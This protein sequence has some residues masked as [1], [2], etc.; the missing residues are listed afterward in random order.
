MQR[1]AL[2]FLILLMVAGIPALAELAPLGVPMLVGS[3][4][5]RFE[6][7]GVGPFNRMEFTMDT[8]DIVFATPSMYNFSDSGWS[9]YFTSSDSR[10]SAA[11]GPAVELLQFDVHFPDSPAVP[12]AFS[13]TAWNN[14]V[15]LELVNGSWNGSS[16]TMTTTSENCLAPVGPPIPRPS[17]VPEPGG[18]LV[19]L[20][21][22]MV[23]L[24]GMFKRGLK[25]V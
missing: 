15:F 22:S 6:E 10:Q 7:S 1:F 14:D 21:A 18:T 24:L 8:P 25:S 2:R 16:W 5:Q 17:S 11:Y 19:I 4:A 9:V 13:F 23:G 12:L 20:G 3:W